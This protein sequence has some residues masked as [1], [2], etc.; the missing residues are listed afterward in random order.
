M[1]AHP[2]AAR[3]L[4]ALLAPF[5][6]LVAVEPRA[7]ATADAAPRG[8]VRDENMAPIAGAAI[9]V[10]DARG[11]TVATTTTDAQGA[12][13]LRAIPFGEYTVEASA[14]GKADAHQHVVVSSST[15]E[16]IEL[17]CTEA[18]Y[19]FRVVEKPPEAALPSRATGSVSQLGRAALQALPQG[20]D[21]AITDVL[22]TQPGFV[23]DAFGNVYAR[24]NHAN[25]QY[26]VDGIPIPDSVGKLFA[27]A[28][29]VR[30]IQD[31]EILTGG[32]PAEFGDRLAAVVNVTSRHGGVTPEGSAQVRYGSFNTV[33][34]GLSYARSLGP[35]GVFVG[36]SYLYSQR[37]LDSPAVTPI[38]HDDGQSGRAFL[39]VD[40][41]ASERYR[42]E[43]FASYAY[44]L[45]Q[46]PID[47]TVVPLDPTRPDLVRPVDQYGNA[48]PPFVPHDTDATE[49]EHE[50]FAAA[51][52]VHAFSERAQL[53][54]APY[55]K[56]SYGALGSDPAHALGALAD[57][58]STASEVTRRADHAG[59]VANVSTR[60]GNHTIKTGAQ[61]DYLDGRTDFAEYVRDDASPAGGID[62]AQ[63]GRGSDHTRALLSGMYLQ[64]RWERGRF[65]LNAGVRIDE[66]HVALAS[67]GSDDQVGVSPRLGV[68]YAFRKELV[69]H[70]FAGVNWQPPSPLDAANAARILGVLPS[71]ASV[72]YDI[73]AQTD[74]YGELGLDGRPWKALRLGAVGWGRYAWNQLDDTAIGE[75]NLIANYNFQRGR[76]VGVEGR[77]ELVLGH[78]LSAFGNVS[79]EIA[80]GQG[81]ASA[82]Y[83]FTPD[84]LANQSWQTLD[85][86]QTLTA[87]LGATVR[88][89]LASLTVLAAYGSGLRTGPNNDQTVPQHVR[90]DAT[91]QLAFDKVPLR[92][93]VAID[94]INLFDAQYA[95]R[96]ANGFVGSSWAAPRSVFAR[97]AIP[98][99]EGG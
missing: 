27:Q 16:A 25:V 95:Y 11:D 86:A 84:Q 24:G 65:S 17:Y 34:P 71:T 99:G 75:T 46:I 64:D 85:H 28:L 70:A 55:Y 82:R 90:V 69:L 6:L 87:N 13:T 47:P 20:D 19:T 68:S 57:P 80:Q 74:A 4:F 49:R 91:L 58:G 51:S 39:R 26:Q 72:P 45:F 56:L 78:W 7:Q 21:R 12:F 37:A 63:T 67:G 31:V 98:L 23:L 44:N 97:L 14:P 38:L 96:I 79:W 81:I 32:M 30:L 42:I 3:A 54:I 8:I 62:P 76:A 83:L 29:P 50:L 33:E 22:A 5:A 52:W 53:Q 60:V 15:T 48:S 94:V 36:G 2:R 35:V 89:K 73:K 61:V 1:P 92:P 88:E 93:R 77:A 18:K 43:V 41:P 59:G 66:Q 10:H 9:V 40:V